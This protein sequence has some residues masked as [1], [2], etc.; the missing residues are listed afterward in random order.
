MRSSFF[1]ILLRRF[2]ALP[3][4][5]IQAGM[6]DKPEEFVR[7]S[8][9]GALYLTAGVSF[10]LAMGLIKFGYV[11]IAIFIAPLVFFML[12][13][14]F[15]RKPNIAIR[16]KK[17]EFDREIVF[18]G[19]FLVIELESGVPVY[20]AM[21]SVTKSYPTIGKYFREILNRVDIGTPIEDAINE[22]IELTPSPSF[23]KILWQIYNSLKTGSDLA[24]ALSV[25][26]EQ[27][28]QDQVIQVK[29]YGKKLNPI[30][31]FY[32]V[33]AIIFPSIGVIM[34][35]VFSGFFSV[36]VNLTA[37]LLVAAGVAFMQLMFLMIMKGQRPSVGVQ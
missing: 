1:K 12:F 27:V 31:M 5:L 30:V 3:E 29:E 17:R 34:F 14:S 13:S 32:M 35:I 4:T 6:M 9:F 36:S 18:A 7:K 22:S 25:T 19:R 15:L 8:F 33:A 10:A 11:K 2:P 16:K 28:A 26:L 21:I 23:R 37:L 20:N 24:S